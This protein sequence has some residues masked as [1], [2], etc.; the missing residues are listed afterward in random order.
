MSKK[1]LV[2]MSPDQFV[3]WLTDSFTDN[4]TLQ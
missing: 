1:K 2:G 4:K 3:R